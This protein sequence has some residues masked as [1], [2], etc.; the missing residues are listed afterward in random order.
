[1]EQADQ[2]SP[3]LAT[4]CRSCLRLVL[5]AFVAYSLVQTAYRVR[6]DPRELAFV[7][8]AYAL[9]GALFL[10]LRRA[11]RLTPESPTGERRR[12]LAAVWV[13]STVLSLSFAYRVAA[14]MPPAVAVLVWCMTAAVV[15]AGLYMLVLCKDQQ[16]RG[17]D[18]VDSDRTGDGH[19][20]ALDDVKCT[21]SHG[22]A[23][24]NILSTD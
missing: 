9:L 8:C 14:L 23:F 12:V 15:L 16:Y 13:L 10:C 19:Y 3:W 11:E 7:V 1:M 17:L 18:G 22:K 6:D 24:E 4:A 2:R 21:A 5:L 20:Q